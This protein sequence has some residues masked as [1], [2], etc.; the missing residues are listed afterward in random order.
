MHAWKDVIYE[1]GN[2]TSLADEDNWVMQCKFVYVWPP[3]ARKLAWLLS[4]HL[5]LHTFYLST[6]NAN[7]RVPTKKL[8]NSFQHLKS[9]SFCFQSCLLCCRF[10]LNNK[11]NNNKYLCFNKALWN[12][13]KDRHEM[14]YTIFEMRITVSL[15]CSMTWDYIIRKWR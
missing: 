5:H 11:N 4:N 8:F 3:T 1:M 12:E 6:L 10:Q 9:I 14:R 13:R 15:K 2:K 7:I